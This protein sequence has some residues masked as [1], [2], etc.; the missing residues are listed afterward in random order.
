M[1]DNSKVTF[2][3]DSVARTDAGSRVGSSVHQRNV[4][5]SSRYLFPIEGIILLVS[6]PELIRQRIVKIGSNVFH[7][8]F[9][10]TGDTRAGWLGRCGQR[11]DELDQ[12]RLLGQTVRRG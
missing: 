5:V 6:Q 9:S 7:P 10:Q 4:C 8:A 11:L 2:G 1:T 3:S 12:R